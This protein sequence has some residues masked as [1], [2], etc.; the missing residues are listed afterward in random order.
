[1][2]ACFSLSRSPPAS[3][4]T[5]PELGRLA[6]KVV[7]LD[8]S[9]AKFP[10][11]VTA[12]EALATND[13][14]R[15]RDSPRFLCSSDELGFDTPARA[16]A[17]EEALQPG[18]LYFVLPASMLRR[19]LSGQD[20]AALAVKA[21]RALAVEAGL[22]GRGGCVSSRRKEGDGEAARGKL[23]KTA[24]VA[25]LVAPS[26]SSKESG[27]SQGTWNQQG[28]S[29]YGT[30]KMG[31]DGERTVGK[32]RHRVGVRSGARRRACVQRLGA[33]AEGSE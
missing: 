21:T 14:R 9:M 3:S 5:P 4:T 24:R 8:G 13:G 7:Y 22:V 2:G 32:R 11:P 26:S 28:F 33:I 1:M 16:M 27:S 12:R 18:Q 23:R 10:G 25:P 6:I 29:E 15:H 30:H 31:Y 17:A 20:M 19:P